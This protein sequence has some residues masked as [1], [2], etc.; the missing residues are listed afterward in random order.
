MIRLQC[1]CFV[2][3]EGASPLEDAPLRE[4]HAAK[5]DT[6]CDLQWRCTLYRPATVMGQCSPGSPQENSYQ[7]VPV[8]GG[9]SDL[10]RHDPRSGAQTAG[11]VKKNSRPSHLCTMQPSHTIESLYTH[12]LSTGTQSPST[13]TGGEAAQ[14]PDV[15]HPSMAVEERRFAAMGEQLHHLAA[16]ILSSD[17]LSHLVCQYAR[18][19]WL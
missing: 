7:M 17:L 2:G 4:D 6:D 1:A 3:L 5:V 8:S 19:R 18:L 10:F 9:T 12:T 16:L 14:S 13:A 11:T 15:T